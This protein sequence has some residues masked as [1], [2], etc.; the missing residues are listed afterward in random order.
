[1]ESP[2]VF[3]TKD[4]N[5]Q[6][7]N[8]FF[9]YYRCPSCDF[10]FLDP[11]PADLG[12]YYPPQY[13]S[14]PETQAQ[15]ETL[16]SRDKHKI[17]LV[18]KYVSGGELLEIGPS[19]GAFCFNAKN[20]GFNVTAIEMD[21]AC[22]R[23]LKETVGVNAFQGNEILPLMD[24]IGPCDVIMLWHVVEHL[25]NAWSV[26]QAVSDKLKPGG[27]LIVSAPNP[28]SLQFKAQGK[29][30]PHVDAP[31]HPLLIP[32]KT[33]V[34]NVEQYGP[35]LVHL[36][37]RD[38]ATLESNIFGW[39]YLFVNLSDNPYIRIA[40]NAFGILIGIIL[41]PLE[42]RKD[43]GSAYTAVFRKEAAK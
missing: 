22:C 14:L 11:V 28:D 16:A 3:R 27:I 32:Y 9:C 34:R 38:P 1:M 15:M 7:T 31:R 39:Q 37:T 23:F 43:W 10:I 29:R 25:P 12:S 13:H 35:R 26:L 2:Q 5:K 41:S 18:K 4:Y 36:T 8:E 30:W 6:V 21:P 20:A 42:K 19:W 40:L 17:D 24:Q 33:L